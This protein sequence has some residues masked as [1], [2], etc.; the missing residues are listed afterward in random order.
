M[1]PRPGSRY[2]SRPAVVDQGDLL[3]TPIGSRMMRVSAGACWPRTTVRSRDRHRRSMTSTSA[4]TRCTTFAGTSCAG[5]VV[6][7]RTGRADWAWRLRIFGVDVAASSRTYQRRLQCEAACALFVELV[8]EAE[9][10]DA[11]AA[12]G[13][14]VPTGRQ[15]RRRLRSLIPSMERSVKDSASSRV[16][17]RLAGISGPWEVAAVAAVTIGVWR[18]ALGWDWSSVP[19][20]DPL[21]SVAPQSGIGLAG[22]RSRGRGRRRMARVARPRRRRYGHRSGCR[23]SFCPAGVWPSPAS[24]AGRSISPR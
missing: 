21:R 10:I 11:R 20:A 3:S 16:R 15:R 7:S 14:F 17:M 13:Q 12:A 23:S 19:S 8:P 5:V 9:V 1:W 18:V 22:A 6:A 4:W 2:I 24:S